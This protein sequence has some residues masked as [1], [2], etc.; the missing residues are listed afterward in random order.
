MN[1]HRDFLNLKR[2]VQIQILQ[3]VFHFHFQFH[4]VKIDH[5]ER[6]LDIENGIFKSIFTYLS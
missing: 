6:S 1:R 2:L 5:A 3:F 4:K